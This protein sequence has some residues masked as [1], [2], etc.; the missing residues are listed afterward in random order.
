MLA[1]DPSADRYDP[2]APGAAWSGGQWS[3]ARF[4]LGAWLALRL[5]ALLPDWRHH[6]GSGR[7]FDFHEG[8]TLLGLL[9][10]LFA[11]IDS[12]AIAAA[13]VGVGVGAALL[14]AL[15]WWART[16]AL[17]VAYLVPCLAAH[18]PLLSLPAAPWL[19][20]LLLGFA[21]VPKEPYLG[22]AARGRVDPD[23]GW[24]LPQQTFRLFWLLLVAG[25][26]VTLVERLA[27]A[28]WRNGDALA[29]LSE[30]PG[31]L[32]AWLAERG[33]AAPSALLRPIAWLAL[34]ADAA[35][36]ALIWQVKW[37]RFT[38][39]AA[40]ATRLLV[41]LLGAGG[42][43]DE[44]L[45]LIGLFAFDPG[46][47]PAPPPTPRDHLFYDGSCGLC[48]RFVRFVLAEDRPTG[49]WFSPLQGAAIAELVDEPTRRSLPDSV[50]VRRAD[51]TLLTKSSAAAAVLARLGGWWRVA[52]ALLRIVP[53]PLRDLGYDAMA[54]LRKRLFAAP[55]AACPLLP[56]ALRARFL[57]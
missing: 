38:W 39:L 18:N 16:A 4:V 2:S 47:L 46:W 17:V 5:A 30:M 26:A 10:N 37:Q 24:R 54:K 23:G 41:V 20:L 14:L 45:L 13:L 22:L 7:L 33:V 56:P 48:H 36:V 43:R 11:W 15:G 55:S 35:L 32:V 52:A 40:L 27:A 34:A 28:H 42:A 21:T 44:A 9:P 12:P 49:F 19:A 31:S 25:C 50:V 29:Q 57:P 8:R 1:F 53:R 6:F 51:G 3:V